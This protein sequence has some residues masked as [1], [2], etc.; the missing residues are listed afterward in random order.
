MKNEVIRQL[1]EDNLKDVMAIIGEVI[2]DMEGKG[3]C[4]WDEIYPGEDI[5]AGDLK[6]KSAYGYFDNGELSAYISVNDNYPPEYDAIAWKITG[7]KSL[8]IHRLSV[9]PGKQGKGIAKMLVRFAEYYAAENGYKTIRL[10]AFSKN[11]AA[12]KLYEGMGYYKSGSCN[13]RKGLFFCFEK[14]MPVLRPAKNT[15]ID[16][17]LNLFRETIA[18]ICKNDYSEKQLEAWASSSK[19]RPKWLERI[20]KQYFLVAEKDSRIAGFGSLENGDHLDL[21]Y[22]RADLI[23]T[24]IGGILLHALEKESAGRGKASLA[25]DASVTARSFFEKHGYKAIKEQKNNINGLEI[26]N[27]KMIKIFTP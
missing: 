3:I 5:I 21:L 22:V 26:M 27:Y 2:P 13:F 10:D 1:S 12:L 18:E 4:Q 23:K 19:N 6:D 7:G 15:D 17:I 9:R 11:P 8:I 25:T 16:E 14:E 20:E 24:G